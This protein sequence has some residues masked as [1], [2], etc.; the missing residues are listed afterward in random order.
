MQCQYCNN[1]F[2]TKSSLSNHQRKDKYCLQ[3]Q[4]KDVSSDFTCEF[5]NSIFTTKVGL[6]YHYKICKANNSQLLYGYL[7]SFL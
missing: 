1:V 7:L 6:Q 4:G 5:C 3:I 2:I